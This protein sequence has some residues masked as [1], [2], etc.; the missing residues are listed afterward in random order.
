MTERYFC[1]FRFSMMVEK[2]TIELIL[3]IKNGNNE[4]VFLSSKIIFLN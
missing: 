1:P 3:Q 4:G 2:V